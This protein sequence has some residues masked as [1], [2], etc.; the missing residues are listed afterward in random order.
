M[1]KM[2]SQKFNVLRIIGLAM[3][4]CTEKLRR[5]LVLSS[6]VTA[7]LARRSHVQLVEDRA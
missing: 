2:F 5:C 6:M 1:L 4:H 3:I 7:I